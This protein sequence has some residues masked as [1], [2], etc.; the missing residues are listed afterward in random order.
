MKDY[1]NLIG[2]GKT[3]NI[4]FVFHYDEIATRVTDSDG[5][6]DLEYPDTEVDGG[7][8]GQFKTYQE[9]LQCVDDKAY[10][11]HVIIEDRLTGVV[12]EQCQVRCNCCGHIE[13]ETIDNIGF[14]RDQLGE[15]FK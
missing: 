10:L 9:A 11:P 1:K 13:Y 3:P 15:S 4:Y 6:I 8:I 5:N 14:T 2:D 12:F 7:L